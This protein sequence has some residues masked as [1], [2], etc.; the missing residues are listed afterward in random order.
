M[1][2]ALRN[3]DQ[4]Y[5]MGI[6][7]GPVAPR[8]QRTRG[9]EYADMLGAAS[10]P[11]SAVPIAGD[12]TG[13]AADA[14]M[15]SA[16]PEERTMG[17]YA[18]SALGVLPLVPG[19]AA[20]RAARG[21][22]SPLE[23]TLDMSTD[24][25]MQR[26]AEQGYLPETVYHGTAADIN[27]FDPSAYGGS[28]TKARSA[29]MGTWFS[30]NPDVSA[31]YA[32]YAA[33]SVP[34]QNLIDQSNRAGRARNFDLQEKLMLEAE[35]LELSGE[36]IGGGGQNVVPSRIKGN[37]MEVDAGGATMSDLDESQ[38]YQWAT[39]AKNKGFDGLKINNF[40]DNADYGVYM[41]ATHYLVFDPSGIRSVNAAFDP[42]MRGSANLLAGAAGA[43]IGLSA[44]RNIQRE[45]EQDRID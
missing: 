13:L 18:M 5:M 27:T 35:N 24:A 12:I 38:L 3:L 28:V 42:A 10:I 19:A 31:T 7:Q 40:S 43:T 23:G 30:D 15:Y 44:L 8:P 37:M 1:P 45:D 36:L 25:R 32:R 11:M 17:N 2:S 33:E 6:G 22:T 4:I 34:V 14:A 29:K 9:Q 21:T 16:Y 39:D 41:P 26:A 20:L